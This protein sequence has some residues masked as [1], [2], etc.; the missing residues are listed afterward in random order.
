MSRF[1]SQLVER[2][3]N[4]T[5]ATMTGAENVLSFYFLSFFFLFFL[6]SYGTNTG[7]YPSIC[8]TMLGNAGKLESQSTLKPMIC[9]VSLS[10]CS[11]LQAAFAAPASKRRDS[12]KWSSPFSPARKSCLALGSA[13]SKN[14]SGG[15]KGT[16]QK[17]IVFERNEFHRGTCF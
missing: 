16:Q 3:G 14:V 12:G 6:S 4:Y 17:T 11:S 13:N 5:I 9:G 7:H 2:I 10:V 8:G 15:K 1:R